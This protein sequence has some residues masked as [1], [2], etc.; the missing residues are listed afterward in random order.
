MNAGGVAAVTCFSLLIKS[1]NHPPDLAEQLVAPSLC[2]KC[3]VAHRDDGVEQNLQIR[4]RTHTVDE[5]RGLGVT[6]SKCVA[7]V[8]ARWPPAEK[9]M[10]PKLVGVNLPCRRISAYER[11]ARWPSASR[12]VAVSGRARRIHDEGGNAVFGEPFRMLELVNHREACVAAA[13]END[14]GRAGGLGG[15]GHIGLMVRT[16]FAASWPCLQRGVAR[17]QAETLQVFARRRGLRQSWWQRW[18]ESPRGGGSRR[19]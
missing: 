14:D 11:T 15:S 17:P 13:R 3:L 7:R 10:T 5:V 18:P 6:F 19:G 1:S 16:S 9:P 8:L 12:R 2:G 4:A